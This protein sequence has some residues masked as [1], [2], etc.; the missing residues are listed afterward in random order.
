[1]KKKPIIISDEQV[2]DVTPKEVTFIGAARDYRWRNKEVVDGYQV[3][4]NFKGNM[5]SLFT[6]EELTKEYGLLPDGAEIN[7]RVY[8]ETRDVTHVRYLFQSDLFHNG[9]KRAEKFKE[10][11]QNQMANPVNINNPYNNVTPL[12]VSKTPV[13]SYIDGKRE[14]YRV[15]VKFD[16]DFDNAATMDFLHNLQNDYYP[17]GAQI[18]D[19]NYDFV[20]H[21]TDVCYV[22]TPGMFGRGEKRAWKLIDKINAQINVAETQKQYYIPLVVGNY[23]VWYRD[24]KFEKLVLPIKF[25]NRDNL[26]IDMYNPKQRREENEKHVPRPETGKYR[27]DYLRGQDKYGNTICYDFYGKSFKDAFWDMNKFR[28]KMLAAMKQNENIK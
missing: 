7:C 2:F 26:E 11:I 19:I 25:Y 8:S 4:I 15:S 21:T 13:I 12:R 18:I 10:K 14:G 1:M 5:M 20:N 22:F 28:I 27:I 16:G 23:C 17:R 24:G 6:N 9:E 3:N